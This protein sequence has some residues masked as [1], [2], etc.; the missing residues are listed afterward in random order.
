MWVT[1]TLAITSSDSNSP[2]GEKLSLTLI[3]DNISSITR[4]IPY[5]FNIQ[6][7]DGK[8]VAS[9]VFGAVAIR[10]SNQQIKTAYVHGRFLITNYE[11]GM[12]CDSGWASG[13]LLLAKVPP[14]TIVL[15]E[16]KRRMEC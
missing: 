5:E 14:N 6:I 7:N 11:T 10:V 4:F 2:K 9:E 1:G 16:P 15:S 13:D 3:P 8:K 12:I